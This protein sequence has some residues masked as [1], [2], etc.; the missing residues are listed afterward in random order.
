MMNTFFDFR[1]PALTI[2][3]LVLL[4]AAKGQSNYRQRQLTMDDG[5]PSNAV[6][7]IVQDQR[8]FIWMGT[9][10]GLCRYDGLLVSEFPLPSS[11]GSH[12][13]A[14]LPIGE[15]ELLV[16]T[17]KGL[18]R[19]SMVTELL[20]PLPLELTK[21]VS[22]LAFDSDGRLW[23][24][25][26]GQGL[27]SCDSD[28]DN[29]QSYPLTDCGGMVNSVYVDTD[30]QV[31][32]LSSRGLGGLWRLN[33]Q[34][35]TFEP[36]Q[37]DDAAAMPT[38][39]TCMLQTSDGN[40]WIGTWEHGLW[41]LN[42]DHQLVHMPA[43][44]T[45]HCHHIH[46]IAQL[47]AGELLLC[48]DDGLWLFDMQKRA[49]DLYQPQRF[50]FTAMRDGEGGLWV[51]TYYGGIVYVSPIA[52]RFDATPCGLVSRFAEDR[53]GRIWVASVGGG[54]ACYSRGRLMADVPGQAKLQHIHAHALCADGDDLWM[55]T[56]NEGVYVFSTVTGQLRQY[57][58]G[59]GQHSLFP[60]SC[61]SIFRD[62]AG[63]IWIAMSEGL[64]RYDRQSDSFERIMRL[65]SVAIDIDEDKKGNIWLSTQGDGLCRYQPDSKQTKYYHNNPDEKTTLAHDI[66]N[67]TLIDPEGRIWIGTQGGLCSYDEKTDGFNRIELD[68][69]RQAVASITGV[70]GAL[71]LS[72]DCGVLKY[73]PGESLLRFTRQDGLVSEQFLPNAV[74]KASDGR[75]YLG[76][77][78]GFNSFFPH[79]IKVNPL[80]APVFI[81][82]LE[83]GNN[84]IPVGNWHLPRSLSDMEQLDLYYNDQ[85]FSL[86]FASLSY[87]SPQKNMYAYMLEGFDKRWNYVESDR[88]AT[89]TNLPAGEYVFRVKATN[90]DGIWSDHEA[91]LKI[92]IHPPFWW[93]T[94]A[95]VAYVLLI[96]FL[97]WAFIFLRLKLAER[98]HRKELYLLNEQKEHEMQQARME[99]FTTIAHEIRT[100]VSLII[101]PLDTLKQQLSTLPQQSTAT[102]QSLDIIDR[103]AHRLLDLVGQLLDFRKV[104]QQHDLTFT[105]L[106]LPDLLRTVAANFGPSF[107]SDGINFVMRLPREAFMAAVDAEALTKVVSNLLSNAR[108][109]TRST[110]TLA[111][112][113]LPDGKHFTIEVTDNGLGI[114]RE[115]QKRVFQPFFQT[116][117]SK[118]GTGIGLSIVKRL[119]EAHHGTVDIDSTMGEGTTFRVT[120]PLQQEVVSEN[121]AAE[122]PSDTPD[123]Q[124]QPAEVPAEQAKPR[125]LIV[126]DNEDMLTFLVTTFMDT[127]DVTPAR[128]GAEA[129]QL[130]SDGLVGKDGMPTSIFD[131]V[132]SDWMMQKM[133]GPELCSR[134]RQNPATARLPFILL[135]A[136]TDSQSKVEAM[137][138]GVDAF[139]EKPFAVKYL[140]A[141]IKNLLSRRE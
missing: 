33:K 23:V 109:Y 50:V 21:P 131:I 110:I 11:S 102:A 53:R 135:T 5:L 124:D 133:D 77:I 59:E 118:P 115:N 103:N 47:S 10:G 70:Q 72:G 130:V 111:C 73:T 14:L 44:T 52:H 129:L 127:F 36:A 28:G 117:G 80:Q 88:R 95:K 38:D 125:M 89:Y 84:V 75:I 67:C 12:V 74:L 7:S 138:K 113:Q 43:A 31:W 119:A 91:R 87:C 126:D 98:R 136:K 63:R 16:G 34:E 105:V 120:L 64:C 49:F 83:I 58:A 94:Y 76:T 9:E 81:T 54:M 114:T 62:H 85:V 29:V 40:R 132:I 100:P 56:Y 65:S 1:R 6:T 18:F 121:A 3:L 19:F 134:L 71:W 123:S 90:N 20:D 108:K 37:I 78:Q 60:S 93:S 122:Q 17:V 61:S 4:S 26:L 139:I 97:I 86:A 66:V 141:C 79:Q 24:S 99:F 69:P 116:V 101:G 39:A 112:R 51:G 8:G 68:V 82:Q 96:V 35:D 92:V 13:T 25:T 22:R 27:L 137:E 128:D 57:Q 45:G 30:N 106:N 107:K 15:N 55:G 42:D 48:C 140:E 46:T 2:L 104:G 32:A 41:Q